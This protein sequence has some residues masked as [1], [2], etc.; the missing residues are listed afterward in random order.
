ERMLGVD[1]RGDAAQMLRLGDHVE[2][3]RGLAGGLRAVD[4]GDPSSR[5]AADAERHV[6]RQGASR[7]D[8]D[9]LEGAAG[10][11]AHDRALAKL[12]LD[13]RDRQLEGQPSLVLSLS[14]AALLHV[15][16]HARCTFRSL[17]LPAILGGPSRGRQRPKSQT[18]YPSLTV[19]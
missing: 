12:P 9:L 3:E 17:W 1:E 13:L 8:R 14:H 19:A 15:S 7:N 11:Q 4:L 2:R 18:E 5:Q 16:S 10:A 6:E